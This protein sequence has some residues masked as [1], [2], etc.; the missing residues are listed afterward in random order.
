MHMNISSSFSLSKTVLFLLLWLLAANE[1]FSQS[2]IVILGSSTAYG[3]G[4]TPISNSWV[5]LF[6]SNQKSLNSSTT[7]VNLAIPGFVTYDI[8]PTGNIPPAGRPAPS[9]KNNI[10]AALAENPT[11]IIISLTS[12]DA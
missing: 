8:L 5:N 3:I 9:I 1:T 11:V 12:N 10:T 4:A 2:K 7:V 6:S